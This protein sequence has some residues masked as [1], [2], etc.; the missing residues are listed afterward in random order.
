MRLVMDKSLLLAQKEQAQMLPAFDEILLVNLE[1]VPP[2][3]IFST[4][5][6]VSP[7]FVPAENPKAPLSLVSPSKI[8]RA[9]C[10]ERV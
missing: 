2:F 8:G 5:F 6:P 7:G 1:D 3:S 10:R 4:S 9:S